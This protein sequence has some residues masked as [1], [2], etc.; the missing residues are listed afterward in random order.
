MKGLKEFKEMLYS[1][2]QAYEKYKGMTDPKAVV[3]KAK[4]DGFDFTEDELL[5]DTQITEA[6]LAAT[7]GGLSSAGVIGP[8]QGYTNIIGS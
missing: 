1:D 7:A 8:A 4:A 5:N 6:E 3:G 2:R